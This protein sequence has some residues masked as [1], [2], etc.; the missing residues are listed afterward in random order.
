VS[1][2]DRR[3]VVEFLMGEGDG[4]GRVTAKGEV[5]GELRRGWEW[6]KQRADGERV[7]P[8]ITAASSVAEAVPLG[9][10]SAGMSK[11]AVPAKRKYEVDVVD[12]EFCKRVSCCRDRFV[13]SADKGT[14]YE[15]KRLNYKIGILYFAQHQVE[16]HM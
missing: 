8:A 3:G 6:D 11:T 14:S 4:G 1:V 9:L 12:R 16:S 13:E 5:L 15:Q 2:A 7:A 10:D